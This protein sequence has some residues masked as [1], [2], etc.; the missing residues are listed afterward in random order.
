MSG[1]E[2]A[3][4]LHEEAVRPLLESAYPQLRYAAARIGAGSEVLG[5]DTA[6]SADHDWGPRL[7]LFL[8]P[9]DARRHGR[10]ITELLAERLPRRI[11]GWSTHYRRTGDPLNPVSHLEP[12]HGPVVDHRVTVHDLPGWLTTHLDPRAAR[13]TDTAPTPT[14][15]L[16]LP[17]Q[18]LAEFTGGAVF[19]DD[20]GLLTA[21]RA[22]LAHYPDQV[23]RYLLASQWQRIAQEEAFVGRCAEVDD[24]LGAA[25]V[26]ARLVRDLM[27]L[28]FLMHRCYAPYSKWLG[29]AFARLDTDPALAPALRAA[30]AAPDHASRERHLCEA[31]ESAARTHNSLG[32]TEPLDPTRRSYHSRPYQVLHADRFAQ[33]LRRTV[34]DPE[35]RD[36]PLIGAVDQW[37]DNTDLLGRPDIV[38]AAVDTLTGR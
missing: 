36:L 20:L 37:A 14:D 3:R 15:W 11:R 19:H 28:A 21:T 31:Y 30:L 12:A 13:W 34:T 1:I 25:V 5:F 24:D 26:T 4:A 7:Q 2:L 32:L 9:E 6:R 18:R 29:S 22:R 8:T 10:A 27:R 33:A 16:A 17:Q 35:L 38:H 23:R